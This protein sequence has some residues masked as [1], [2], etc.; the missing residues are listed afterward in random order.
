MTRL[1]N[2]VIVLNHEGMGH[3]NPALGATI[4]ANLLRLL[5]QAEER[6]KAVFCYN[7]GVKL[8]VEGSP[9]LQHLQELAEAGVP[10]QA[11]KTC[12]D[13]Y[14]LRDQLRVGEIS[15]MA[16]FVEYL[17]TCEVVTL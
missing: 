13:F 1:A 11:C 5:A 8:L 9:V 14:N 6:P 3:G 16:Q 2:K 4:L 10:I 12:V 7:D 15:S 17:E